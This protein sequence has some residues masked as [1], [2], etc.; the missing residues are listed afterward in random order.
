MSV[1][2]GSA[3]RPGHG[4]RPEHLLGG[5]GDVEEAVQVSVAGVDIPHAGGHAGHALLR[6]QQEQSLGGVQVDLVP[7][8][9]GSELAREDEPTCRDEIVEGRSYLSRQRN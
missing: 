1:C 3:R 6:H 2:A 5:V 4:R 8:R 9:R 7:E